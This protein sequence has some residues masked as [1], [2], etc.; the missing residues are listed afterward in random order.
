[1]VHKCAAAHL[2][3]TGLTSSGFPDDEINRK[4]SR[5]AQALCLQ[6]GGDSQGGGGGGGVYRTGKQVV[7]SATPP[8]PVGC[9]VPGQSWAVSR[10]L[11]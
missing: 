5:P 9:L 10:P 3:M 8:T 7:I 1:M 4:L 11:A 2:E 6:C